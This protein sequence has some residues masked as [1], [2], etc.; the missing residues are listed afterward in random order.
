MRLFLAAVGRGAGVL[1]FYEGEIFR[2]CP[3]G[4]FLV[5]HLQLL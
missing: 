5:L 2:C 3:G 1:P 4:I